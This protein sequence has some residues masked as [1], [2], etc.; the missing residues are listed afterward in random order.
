MNRWLL[1]H[2]G[3]ALMLSALLSM[4]CTSTPA[5]S[6]RVQVSDLATRAAP[7]T[8]VTIIPVTANFYI[9]P[10]HLQY[11]L[12]KTG[13]RLN[14]PMLLDEPSIYPSKLTD[15]SQQIAK[16]LEQLL[17]VAFSSRGFT[18]D[19]LDRNQVYADEVYL[20]RSQIWEGLAD[21][22]QD[23]STLS[24][25]FRLSLD[26]A[27][28]PFIAKTSSELLVFADFRGWRKTAGDA[29]ADNVS[30][31]PFMAPASS[32]S[33]TSRLLVTLIDTKSGE[34]LWGNQAHHHTFSPVP[35]DYNFDQL[36]GL[37]T[38]ALAPLALTRTP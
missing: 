20:L 38:E 5:L 28:T 8:R 27:I 21:Q 19:P 31:L 29:V 7:Y 24:I 2:A 37:L 33:G 22:A 30:K 25:H 23:K 4:G 6:E 10:P 14:D 1:F 13:R 3:A 32:P 12:Q 18:V 26:S 34:L 17:G 35:P 36:K 9:G 11:A 15:Q 16:S